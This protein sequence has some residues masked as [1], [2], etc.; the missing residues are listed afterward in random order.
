MG[1]CLSLCSGNHKFSSEKEVRSVYF[2]DLIIKHP[3]YRSKNEDLKQWTGMFKFY[4]RHS[5][6]RGMLGTS[7][8]VR[9]ELF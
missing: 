4:S 1:K 9:P 3:F 6:V 8:Y 7:V 2:I 5:D